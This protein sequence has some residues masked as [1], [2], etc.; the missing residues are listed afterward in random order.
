MNELS[1]QAI[2]MLCKDKKIT[3]VTAFQIFCMQNRDYY[4][5][6][7]LHLKGTGITSLL[8]KIWRRMPD[9]DKQQYEDLSQYI[10]TRTAPEAEQKTTNYTFTPVIPK[11]S[12]VPRRSF[13][14]LASEASATVTKHPVS[15]KKV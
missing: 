15:Q 13:G 3:I 11:I 1:E 12:V 6:L 7:N 2:N 10:R 4:A 5:R 14:T 9:Q 8:A